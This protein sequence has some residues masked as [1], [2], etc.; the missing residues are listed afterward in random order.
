MM[1]KVIYTICVAALVGGCTPSDLPNLLVKHSPN[2]APIV[3]GSSTGT[4]VPTIETIPVKNHNA[5]G[6][7]HIAGSSQE[8]MLVGKAG[9]ISNVTRTIL[10]EMRETDDGDMIFKPARLKVSQGE[11]IKF[12]IV[13]KGELEHE[14]VLDEHKEVLK[15]K[16]MMERFPEMEH[17]DPNSIRLEPGKRG[18][19][20]WN[21]ANSGKFEFACLVPGHYDAG[22][23]GD[24]AVTSRLAK[25]PIKSPK[26]AS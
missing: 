7:G 4:S 17:D 12:K 14:F 20:V 23:K 13:N 5:D 6:H 11:T 21:F 16:A 15:H 3:A 25:K 8:T 26:K 19:I 22:M 2:N 24:L 18:N 1:N 10:V 9:K